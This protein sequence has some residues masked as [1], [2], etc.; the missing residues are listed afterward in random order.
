MLK[1]RSAAVVAWIVLASTVLLAAPAGAD[2]SVRVVP[3]PTTPGSPVSIFG[4]G[5]CGSPSCPPV[6]LLIDGREVATASA[7][8]D[9][10]VRFDVLAPSP[11]NQHVVVAEQSGSV[12]SSATTGLLVVPSDTAVPPSSGTPPA[13]KSTTRTTTAGRQPPP[14]TATRPTST[15]V[16]DGASAGSARSSRDRAGESNPA[17]AW[18]AILIGLAVLAV[19][20]AGFVAARR[21]WNSLRSREGKRSME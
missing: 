20:A 14:S 3:T 9:G 18:I 19:L 17:G 2:P 13:T 15:R 6:R 7:Q 10:S 16:A 5:F 1:T 11:P 4:S 21:G 8:P 12:A